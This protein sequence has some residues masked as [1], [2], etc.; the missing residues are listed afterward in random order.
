MLVY[1]RVHLNG[2]SIRM[3]VFAMCCSSWSFFLE[4]IEEQQNMV[5]PYHIF[6]KIVQ[7][8]LLIISTNIYKVVLITIYIYSSIVNIDSPLLQYCCC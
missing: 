5:L 1:Q 8:V 3:D 7:Y 2:F 6:L 4:N